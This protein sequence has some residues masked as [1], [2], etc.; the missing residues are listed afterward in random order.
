MSAK[1]HAG[2]AGDVAEFAGVEVA[3]ALGDLALG[4][5]D[6]GA[7]EGDGCPHRLPDQHGRLTHGN[8]VSGLGRVVAAVQAPVG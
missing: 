3:E 4:V 1:Q 2:L 6:E 8:V 7:A 5:H